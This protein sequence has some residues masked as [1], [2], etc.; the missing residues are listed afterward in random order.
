[1]GM[2]TVE[3]SD[4]ETYTTVAITESPVLKNGSNA[5]TSKVAVN[6]WLPL[7][8]ILVAIER[9]NKWPM[10]RQKQESMLHQTLQMCTS[11]NT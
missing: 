5:I 6:R 4:T 8:I 10:L 1:M 7:R 9:L 3:C 2:Y 11:S